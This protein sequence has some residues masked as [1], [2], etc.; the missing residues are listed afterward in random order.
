MLLRIAFAAVVLAA[1]VVDLWVV[2]DL[3]VLGQVEARSTL[4]ILP[5][6]AGIGLAW[7]RWP[8]LTIVVAV[9]ASL[10]SIIETAGPSHDG[11][12]IGVFTEFVV[13]PVLLAAVLAGRGALRWP[14]AALVFVAAES[15]G[16]RTDETSFRAIIAISMLVLL[17]AAAAAVVY[18]RLRDSER[19]TSIENARYNER[20]D[21]ARELHDVVGH[22]VTG[23]VVLAQASRFTSGAPRD[24]SADRAF[25]EI[26]TA[27][28]ETLTSVRRLIGLLRTDPSMSSGPRL[29]DIEKLIE[30]LRGSHPS[31]D[32]I[33]DD[34][35]RARWVPPDLANTVQRLVQE[36]A[37]NVRRHGDP[38]ALVR[39]TLRYAGN[40]FEL[41]VENRMLRPPG[42][43]GFGVVG[44]RERVDALRGR[45]EA[46]PKGNGQWVVRAEL[47]IMEF[48]R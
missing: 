21:L 43:T 23:I 3:W 19:L 17:G 11:L 5:A 1:L 22:H 14:I 33:V 16:F 25:A 40:A 29:T 42:D 48:A 46:G 9:A 41:T 20:L 27:G 12:R 28:L 8:S 32:L 15:I 26:E 2:G 36:A 6:I 10:L 4:L 34:D 37:T 24:S 44:M 39:F 7:A 35:V 31:T 45:F 13:L 47:P 30:D 38:T 18:I